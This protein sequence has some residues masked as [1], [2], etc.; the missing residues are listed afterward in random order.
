MKNNGLKL[1]ELMKNI[2]LHTVRKLTV[3]KVELKHRY[4]IVKY[5]NIIVKCLKDKEKIFNPAREK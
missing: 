4:I 2:N 5:L 1:S 3:P